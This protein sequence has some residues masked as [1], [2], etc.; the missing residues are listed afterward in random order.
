[1]NMQTIYIILLAIIIPINSLSIFDGFRSKFLP[2]TLPWYQSGLRFSC[3][4]CGKCCKVDGD[5]WLSPSEVVTMQKHLELD[6][7]E[8]KTKYGRAEVSNDKETWVCLKRSEEGSCV[9]LNPIGQCG[10]YDVRPIQCSTYPFWPSLLASKE[11]WEDEA[12][13]P[14]ELDLKEGERYWSAE[15]GGCEGIIL[16]STEERMGTSAEEVPLVNRKEIRSKMKAARIHW[17]S[18]PV[19]EIK[20]STWYL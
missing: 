11:D 19:E 17:N 9:F 4:S 15:L 3:T 14:D 6:D 20:Q 1:M 16:Q 2:F 10:I 7:E 12:V 5:V 8:F 18:F 13:I